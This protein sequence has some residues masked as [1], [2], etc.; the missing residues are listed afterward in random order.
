MNSSSATR[1]GE[2]LLELGIKDNLKTLSTSKPLFSSV[3][4]TLIQRLQILKRRQ[5]KFKFM[6]DN[7]NSSCNKKLRKCG[8]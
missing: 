6:I 8:K 2:L 3:V 4:Q 7:S 5:V 1:V